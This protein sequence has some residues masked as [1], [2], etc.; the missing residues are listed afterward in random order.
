MSQLGRY[1]YKM[2]TWKDNWNNTVRYVIYTDKELK[3]LMRIPPKTPL[4][5]FVEKYFIRDGDGSEILTDEDVRI[6][7]SDTAAYKTRN[8]F[9]F[10]RTKSF[11]I[12]VK[13]SILH[14]DQ[15]DPFSNDWMKCRTDMIAERLKV[16]LL[17]GPVHGLR[18]EFGDEYDL[19]T[20]TPGY[21]RYHI[22]FQY[23]TTV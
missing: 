10:N 15:D 1:T 7:Y 23:T 4:T 8:A 5:K 6:V 3:K 20:K 21:K 16:L 13:D 22:T 9:V 12:Y 17:N 19:W 11:D 2:K 18:F 14:P